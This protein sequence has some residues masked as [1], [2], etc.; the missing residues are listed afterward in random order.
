M[1]DEEPLNNRFFLSKF[2]SSPLGKVLL[3]E[4][5]CGLWQADS[6]GNIIQSH[7]T[8]SLFGSETDDEKTWDHT[9][10]Y[11]TADRQRIRSCVDSLH[12]TA[13]SPEQISG[14]PILISVSENP[15]QIEFVEE[16]I[17]PFHDSEGRINGCFA[18]IKNATGGGSDESL[19]QMYTQILNAI[20]AALYITSRDGK[21]RWANNRTE[22]IN[23]KAPGSLH[24]V[25]LLDLIQPEH[26]A[27]WQK[28]HEEFF[29]TCED[30]AFESQLVTAD[31]D[32]IDVHTVRTAYIDRSGSFEGH[33]SCGRDISE[34]QANR[35]LLEEQLDEI[36]TYKTSLDSLPTLIF[37][38][39]ETGEWLV[40][41]VAF[42]AFIDRLKNNKDALARVMSVLDS[43]KPS[44]GYDDE[45]LSVAREITVWSEENELHFQAMVSPILSTTGCYNGQFV[46]S[47]HDITEVKVLEQKLRKLAETDPL[48]GILNR[49]SFLD[50]A[51][52]RLQRL[53]ATSE[54]T[55]AIVFFDLDNFKQINDVH[56]HQI[57][58][59]ALVIAGNAVKSKISSDDL[60]GRWGGEEFVVLL[61]GT[62]KERICSLVERLRVA[63]EEISLVTTTGEQI[64]ISA[65]FGIAHHEPECDLETLVI[66]ADVAAYSA[67]RSGKNQVSVWSSSMSD[68][69]NSDAA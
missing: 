29:E 60:L 41:N 45:V 26:R 12:N 57:G 59:D 16:Y 10:L 31:G 50:S 43:L 38:R 35:R 20:P 4:S 40:K 3:A 34:L 30:M 64:K 46:V 63:I 44:I 13:Q 25:D 2:T 61:H 28:A 39:C 55:L 24:G 62:N 11:S 21:I 19:L 32:L 23:G 33:I 52:E 49:R 66:R 54:D 47:L 8:A 37:G 6:E 53:T 17:F 68:L 1:D 58:D 18:L 69:H 22:A 7:G 5:K 36:R 42:K 56:G 51:T 48:T 14:K 9:V 27:S 15:A 67:K 65:S